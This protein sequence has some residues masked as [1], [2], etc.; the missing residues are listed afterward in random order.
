VVNAREPFLGMMLTLDIRAIVQT[1]SEMDVPRSRRD[2]VSRSISF[3]ALD[4]ALLDAL[5]R[6]VTPLDEPALV[7][8]LAPLIQQEIT[9][10]LLTGPHS[11]QLRRLVTGDPRASRS[12]KPSPGSS[13]TS[14]RRSVE[15]TWRIA[16]T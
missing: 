1:A 8:K 12:R 6:L 16:R 5:I 11:S 4:A 3:R 13:R 15:T 2:D 10:R 7:T 9:I 14:W